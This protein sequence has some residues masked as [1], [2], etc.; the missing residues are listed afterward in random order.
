MI[1]QK[2]VNLIGTFSSDKIKVKYDDKN[3]I[4]LYRENGIKR[5]YKNHSR[6]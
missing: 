4:G 5:A 1:A 2:Y 3:T 6:T